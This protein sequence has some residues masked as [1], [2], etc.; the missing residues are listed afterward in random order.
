LWRHGEPPAAAQLLHLPLDVASGFGRESLDEG[1]AVGERSGVQI[2]QLGDAIGHPVGHARDHK[3]GVA[4]P[5]EHDVVV[6]ILE[7]YE[8]DHVGDMGFEVDFG[9]CEVHPFAQAGEGDG[10]DI[11]TLLSESTGDSLPTPAPEPT[12]TDQH[13]SCHPKALLLRQRPSLA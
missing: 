9:A 10:I 7:L 6:E 12:T 13:V 8:L 5:Q 11:V 2:H 4:V 1:G 3:T